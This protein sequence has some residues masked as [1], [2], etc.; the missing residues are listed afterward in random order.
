MSQLFVLAGVFVF[1]TIFIESINLI[2]QLRGKKLTK[3]FGDHAFVVHASITGILWLISFAL[4]FILQFETHPKFHDIII[5]R[6]F[7]LVLLIIGGI[8]AS[9]AFKLLGM[10]RALCINFFE[11]NVPVVRSSLYRYIENPM[12]IGFWLAL[13]G[14][15]LFTGSVYNLVIAIE[16]I[17]VMYPHMLLENKKMEK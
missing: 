17:A 2:L 12:D 4:L 3:W 11:E 13:I 14:F 5:L 9:W 7:G 6:Y 1:L 16:F 15:S 10:R 8:L